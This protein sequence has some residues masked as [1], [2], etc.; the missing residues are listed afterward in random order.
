MLKNPRSRVP[1]PVK[2]LF[3]FEDLCFGGTQ[4]QN[5][6][7][8]LRLDRARFS[9]VIL[10]LTGPT[11]MDDRVLAADI[12]LYHLGKT[13][14]VPPMFFARLGRHLKEIRPDILLPC[15]ALPNIWGRIWGKIRRVPAIIGT[16]RGG[17]APFRQHERFLWRLADGIICNSRQLFKPMQDAGVDRK[18]MIYIPN[19]VDTERFRPI[20]R[21]FS[22]KQPLIVCVAR[23]AKDKDHKTLIRAFA[24]LLETVPEARLRL[25]GEGPEEAHLRKFT[26]N[27]I[28]QAAQARIE[29]AGPSA[30]PEQHYADADI[31]ALASIREGQPNVI[32]EAMSSCRPICA[33]AVGAI[34][35]LLEGNGLVSLPGD[36]DGLADNFLAL[37]R[38]PEMAAHMARQGRAKAENGYSYQAMVS[39]HQYYFL[40]IYQQRG[41]GK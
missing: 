5:L 16:C 7:L 34:P 20:A 9:P 29:F 17:G 15:T 36:A 38:A 32:L 3:L 21:T 28:P 39:R 22:A 25:V 6:E 30:T 8:A 26:Q 23:L 4:T 31:C 1:D 33:T 41:A 14:S 37:L 11:D 18:R 2:V 35:E 40:E 10:T 27:E 19:G 24:K 12:P 13:R